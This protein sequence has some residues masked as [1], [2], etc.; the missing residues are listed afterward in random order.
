MPDHEC[1]LGNSTEMNSLDVK[2]Q[3]RVFT[4]ELS[5]RV[6]QEAAEGCS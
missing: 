1:R 6:T 3:V 5:V 2:L 4:P